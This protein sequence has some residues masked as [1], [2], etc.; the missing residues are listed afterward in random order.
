M[1]GSPSRVRSN[2][3]EFKP[4]NPTTDNGFNKFVS[5][6]LSDETEPNPNP[7]VFHSGFIDIEKSS[8]NLHLNEKYKIAKDLLASLEDSSRFNRQKSV[9]NQR[10]RTFS[11]HKKYEEPGYSTSIRGLDHSKNMRLEENNAFYKSII[12][13]IISPEISKRLIDS[14]RFLKVRKLDR[15]QSQIHP[16]KPNIQYAIV[17]LTKNE[18]YM[19]Q[20]TT[21]HNNGQPTNSGDLQIIPSP[22]R[23]KNQ[24]LFVVAGGGVR[25]PALS[26]LQSI[27]KKQSKV[28]SN[29]ADFQ[30]F[31]PTNFND[32]YSDFFSTSNMNTGNQTDRLF[33]DF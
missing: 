28:A 2:S 30:D 7:N 27:V 19:S 17:D 32:S 23:R 6:L 21:E 1:P 20:Q 12:E 29:R 25:S 11:S 33:E 14:N 24:D 4:Y 13:E 15:S 22:L 26:Y 9:V 16:G 18:I 10:E 8:N 3:T 5:S 31:N